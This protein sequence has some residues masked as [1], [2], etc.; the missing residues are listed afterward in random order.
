MTCNDRV[1]ALSVLLWR[2]ERV[3]DADHSTGSQQFFTGFQFLDFSS[4]L[5]SNVFNYEK[6]I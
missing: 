2:S 3:S 6:Y 1:A 4:N 5:V